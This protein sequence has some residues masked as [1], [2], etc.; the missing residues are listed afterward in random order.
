MAARPRLRDDAAA[1]EA[2]I[3][4]MGGYDEE[5]ATVGQ[6]VETSHRK[7]AKRRQNVRRFVH[8]PD[9]P[10]QASGYDQYRP[11]DPA[12]RP[13]EESFYDRILQEW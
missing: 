10:Q 8:R 7:R 6:F 5:R 13:N 1:A 2:F 12:A 3:V 9:V 11:P 4:R